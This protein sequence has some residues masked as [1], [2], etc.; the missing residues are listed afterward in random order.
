MLD[1]II[2]SQFHLNEAHSK[3]AREQRAGKKCE[4]GISSTCKVL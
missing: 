4:K 2:Y 1:V 3:I